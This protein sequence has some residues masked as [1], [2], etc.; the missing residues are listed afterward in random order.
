MVDD[1]FSKLREIRLKAYGATRKTAEE[2]WAALAENIF[3]TCY[4][5]RI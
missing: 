2:S 5:K 1:M 4:E 3:S